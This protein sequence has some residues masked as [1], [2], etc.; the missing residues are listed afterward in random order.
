MTR[1]LLVVL[2]AL[3]LGLSVGCGGLGDRPAPDLRLSAPRPGLTDDPEQASLF[4][5]RQ[6]LGEGERAYPTRLMQEKLEELRDREARLDKTREA[7][8][9]PGGVSRWQELGPGNIG[10][11]TRKLLIDPTDPRVMYAGGVSGGVWKSI[12]EGA[13]WRA[14]DDLMLNLAIGALAF[15]PS[16]PRVLYAGTGEGFLGMNSFVRGLGIFKSTDAGATW[17]QLE[18][19]VSVEPEHAFAY[20]NDI[21]ITPSDPR[22]LYAATISGVW[23]SLDAGESWSVVLANPAML[24]AEPASTGSVVGCTDLELAGAP[25]HE[26]ILAAFGSFYADGLYRSEDGGDAWT[27]IDMGPG[28]GRMTLAVAP[29]SPNVLYMCMA[30]NYTSGVGRLIDVFRSEDGG[31]TWHARVDMN[32]KIGPW[33]LSNL[34][35]ATGCLGS[36]DTYHQGWYDNIIAVDPLDPDVVWVGGIDLFRSD[37]GGRTWGIASYWYM[38]QITEGSDPNYVHAD[39][40]GLVF[41]PHYDGAANQVLYST[42]DGGVFRTHNARAATSLE[43]CPFPAADPMP[44]IAWESLNHGYGVTQF[45]HGDSALNADV[46]L[47]GCQDNGTNLVRSTGAADH[48]EHI[49]GGDGGYVAVDP[50]DSDVLYVEYQFF[51]TIHKSTDGGREFAPAVRGITDDDGLFITPFAMD[52]SQPDVLW[53]G[54]RRPWRTTNGAA[55]WEVAGFGFGSAQISAIAVAPSDSHVVY[56]GLTDGRVARTSNALDVTPYWRSDGSGLPQGWVSSVAVDPANPDVA[57]CTY[58]NFGIP[59]VFRTTDR[60]TSW[61]SIDGIGADGVPEIPVHWLAVRPCDSRQLFVGTELGVFA[62]DDVGDSWRPVNRGLAHTVVETLDFKDENTLVAFTHGRGA[63]LAE[64]SPCAAA[65]RGSGSGG[66]R[67]SP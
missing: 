67:L 4:F 28:Q 27:R 42:N 15:D 63:F 46:F 36:R 41:H 9:A 22:R 33:L 10:G 55:R 21:V 57:Y 14:T 32:A 59:H 50:R 35:L 20:V 11:R 40:H 19:T 17:R 30:G 23:R 54:G 5:L 24:S 51:P 1:T 45:Y 52:P 26:V 48:W 12:D 56:M 25:G 62:S 39:Q 3:L 66:V 13:N 47:G 34:V 2:L 18:A 16:D 6:R 44:E 38:D 43:D 29:S 37:D 61:T 7:G 64:L 58:S 60:G 53:S 65:P 31:L 49:F 8:L